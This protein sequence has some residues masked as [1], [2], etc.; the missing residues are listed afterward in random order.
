MFCRQCGQSIDDEVRFCPSCGTPIAERD[1]HRQA[2]SGNEADEPRLTLKPVFVPW[3]VM[4]TAGQRGTGLAV[5]A[6]LGVV[7]SP[8]NVLTD[9]LGWSIPNWLAGVF[10]GA[11][12]FL[13]IAIVTYVIR[14]RTYG[15]TN[16]RFYPDR[17]EYVEGF[18][19][20]EQKSVPYDRITEVNLRRGLIQRMYGLGTISLTTPAT[21]SASAGRSYSG[22]RLQDIREPETFYESVKTLVKA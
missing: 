18:W 21:V 22:I 16:Y 1:H 11:A 6:G 15:E 20:A 2:S 12:C 9:V 7:M 17:L 10:M 19:T 13:V 14:K 8:R 3:V 4:A 5:L